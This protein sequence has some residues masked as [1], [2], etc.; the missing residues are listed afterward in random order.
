MAQRDCTVTTHFR[1]KVARPV[2]LANGLS[3]NKVDWES[4]T[5]LL[6]SRWAW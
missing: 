4:V 1:R 3:D 2:R 6:A 5:K